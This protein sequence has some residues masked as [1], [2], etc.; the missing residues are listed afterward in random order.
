M[1][2]VNHTSRCTDKIKQNEKKSKLLAHMTAVMNS[3]EPSNITFKPKG[4]ASGI[5]KLSKTEE[6]S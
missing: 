3:E 5:R 6:F 4:N 1:R 2:R